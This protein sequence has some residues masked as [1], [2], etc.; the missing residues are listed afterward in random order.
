MHISL[1]E[2]Q[3]HYCVPRGAAVGLSPSKERNGC[4]RFLQMLGDSYCR[5]FFIFYPG[6]T[7]Q[8]RAAGGRATVLLFST[9]R[10]PW[11]PTKTL[12]ASKSHAEKHFT[13][14]VMI[15][16]WSL[17]MCSIS[18]GPLIESGF[19]A[20]FSGRKLIHKGL[21]TQH[22]TFIVTSSKTDWKRC[23]IYLFFYSKENSLLRDLPSPVPTNPQAQDWWKRGTVELIDLIHLLKGIML[24]LVR[25]TDC[26][27][28]I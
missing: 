17:S 25:T 23:F 24:E 12:R 3:L 15:T 5:L 9:L 1:Y 21:N 10:S 4:R 11:K 7:Q 2:L 28:Q 20:A 27:V 26:T 8:S 18:D 22:K 6:R 16:A 19:Q 14:R 13:A